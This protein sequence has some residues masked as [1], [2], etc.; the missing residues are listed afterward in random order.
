VIETGNKLTVA[1]NFSDSSILTAAKWIY[2]LSYSENSTDRNRV[3]VFDLS[4]LCIPGKI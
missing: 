3:L 1:R 4:I 2:F